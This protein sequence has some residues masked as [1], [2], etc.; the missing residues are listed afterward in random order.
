MEAAGAGVDDAKRCLARPAARAPKSAAE[1]LD[2]DTFRDLRAIERRLSSAGVAEDEDGECLRGE[3]GDLVAKFG[4]GVEDSPRWA[5]RESQ[6]RLRRSAVQ[7][8][9][10]G[11]CLQLETVSSSCIFACAEATG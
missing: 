10:P 6:P 1:L 2:G 7:S 3:V 9:L 11:G 5:Q 8:A 4:H